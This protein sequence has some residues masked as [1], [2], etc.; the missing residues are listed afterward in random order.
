MKS[1]LLTCLSDEANLIQASH[2]VNSL[3]KEQPH[4]EV[5]ILTFKDFENTAKVLDAAKET[6]FIDRFMIEHLKNGA[7]YSDAFA[8]NT[9]AE[10]I[11]DVLQREWD[12][13]INFSNDE[14]SAALVPMLQTER[15]CGSSVSMTGTASTSDK[16]SAYRNFYANTV[17]NP[18]I[19]TLSC[20]HH[21]AG[22]PYVREGK[23]IALNQDF[24]MLANQNFARIRAGKG[25]ESL[26]VGVNLSPS[27]KGNTYG[28]PFLADLIETIESSSEFK[29][30]LL[31]QGSEAEKAVVDEL[32]RQFQNSLISVNMDITAMPSV[33]ANLDYLVTAPN[34]VCAVADAMDTKVIEVVAKNESSI[35]YNEGN[36]I[37]E[38]WDADQSAD[39]VIFL[40]N[41]ECATV[42]PMAN[43]H[44]D[45]KVFA[46]ATDDIGQLRT[47]IRGKL[48][49]EQELNYHVSRCYHYALMG[50][51]ID[52]KLIQNL[53]Q[54]TTREQMGAYSQKAKEEITN[55]VK[56]LLA[57]LRS[58]QNIKQSEK[59]APKFVQYLDQLMAFGRTSNIAQA[60]VC[61]FEA[62]VENI[63]FTSA[64][65]N[66]EE[67]EKSL[68]ALKGDLQIL[69]KIFEALL[70]DSTDKNEAKENVNSI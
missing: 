49:I 18:P 3:R 67:I 64:E 6:F 44:S 46:R 40:L 56:T 39:D 69:T 57:T 59:N 28:I 14:I 7:L 45:N 23:K 55:V 63:T 19:D 15:F 13:V 47:L 70:S 24:T 17:M 52:E 11:T 5:A 50:Y 1:I 4:S 60:A 58:L 22:A 41:Q 61:L 12:Q 21:S 36:Y 51:P 20:A 37:I 48:D 35:A 10:N 42:L 30:V 8:I 29:A 62:S 2:L 43:K 68:F 31:L 65:K 38:E 54:N 66:M 16:W 25:G 33:I 27:F 34:K 53:R 9:L 32:N 26:I